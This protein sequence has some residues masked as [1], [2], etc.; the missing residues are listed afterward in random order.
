MRGRLVFD[1]DPQL[2]ARRFAAYCLPSSAG[3]GSRRRDIPTPVIAFPSAREHQTVNA[4]MNPIPTAA[5]GR[6]RP[7]S[8]TNGKR[9]AGWSSVANASCPTT[10][11]S[12]SASSRPRS[13]GATSTDSAGSGLARQ[14]SLS[15]FGSDE[16]FEL[17]QKM[18]DF[19]GDNVFVIGAVG[20]SPAV[21]LT[22]NDLRTCP[23]SSRSPTA[24]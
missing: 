17:A 16:W 11:A 14:L 9:R 24:S 23:P 8:T 21:L 1:S 3:P 7:S 22:N 12:C 15:E 18:F 10:A 6:R 2:S 5:G 13:G 4:R 19:T 20:K